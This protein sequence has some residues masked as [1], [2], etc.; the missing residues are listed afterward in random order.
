MIHLLN[1]KGHIEEVTIVRNK[2][3]VTMIVVICIS[4]TE[5]KLLINICHVTL[6]RLI[7]V[8]G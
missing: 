1:K 8:Q 4:V 2:D 3:Y 5:K 7:R 6:A